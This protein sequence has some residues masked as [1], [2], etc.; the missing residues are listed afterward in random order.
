MRTLVT[1]ATGFIGSTLFDRLLADGHQ[2]VGLDDLSHDP[3]RATSTTP[4]EQAQFDFMQADI[5]DAD[6]AGCSRTPVRNWCSTWPRRSTCAGRWTK[7]EFDALVARWAPF[8]SPRRLGARACARSS[9]PPPGGAVYG[10]PQR[11]PTAEVLGR[12]GLAVYP[13]SKVAPLSCTSRVSAVCTDWT[14]HMGAVQRLSG[15]AQDPHGE[16]GVV[17][18]FARAMLAGRP[19]RL[20]GDGTNTRDYVYVDDVVDA[21]IRAAG[22]DSS[23][24]RFNIG[25][26]VETS[27]RALHSAVAA[28][29]G[30]ADD[31]TFAP[32]R[33]GPSSGHVSTRR[34]RDRHWA[35]VRRSR[36]RRGCA[37]PSSTSGPPIDGNVSRARARALPGDRLVRQCSG[38]RAFRRATARA[39]SGVAQL[40]FLESQIGAE[41]GEHERDHQGMGQ[42]VCHGPRPASWPP[43]WCRPGA[44]RRRPR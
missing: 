10:V 15:H 7:P 2:V 11:Y 38:V 17:A 28:T 34:R 12:S 13:A 26:G 20:F 9:T 30:V 27:D 42:Q 44:A 8:G 21:F 23:G 14:A 3:G 40:E 33:L 16:A 22:P 5:V 19:T 24:L 1:G 39:Q 37:G 43:R 36:S 25:T 18:V 29:V 35:G 41:C 32:P 31:P 4:A 6:L